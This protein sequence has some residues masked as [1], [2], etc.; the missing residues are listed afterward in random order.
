MLDIRPV[1]NDPAT[2]ELPRKTRL[3]EDAA[4]R[5]GRGAQFFQPNLA[6]RFEGAGEAPTPNRFG[7]LQSGCLHCGECDIGCNV[8]AKNTFDLN[9]LAVAEQSGAHV[10][11]RAEVTWLAPEDDGYRIRFRDHE[12]GTERTVLARNVFLCM[13]AVSTTELLLRC[14]DQF[15]TLPRLS[16]RLGSGYSG[17]GDFLAFGL[18]VSPPFA[19]TN[20]PTITTACVFDYDHDGRRLRFTL[21]DGGVSPQGA[22]LLPLLHPILLARLAMRELEE[23]VAHHAHSFT[24]RV[25][26]E[27]DAMVVLLVMGRDRANG[28]I[29]LTRRPTGCAFG[30]I[31]RRTRS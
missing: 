4:V 5:L 22:R 23:R 3:M 20:G 24:A 30:G 21:E 14:R 25:E 15:G 28:S 19:P 1:E 16:P 26:Q 27:R 13:G 12:A 29:E 8:G 11:T 6:V 10:A 17:N 18:D 2:G 9:Y 31:R 7:A